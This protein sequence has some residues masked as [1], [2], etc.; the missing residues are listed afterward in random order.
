MTSKL[1]NEGEFVR[2]WNE[3]KSYEW[4]V[5]KYKSKYDIDIT[6]GAIGNW[7]ARLGL[8]RRQE[9]DM[10]LIP[11]A[12]RPEHRHRHAL[13]MLRALGR[14]RAGGEMTERMGQLLD[15]WLL[16]LQESDAVVY[17]DPDTEEGFFY[18]PREPGDADIIRRPRRSTRLRGKRE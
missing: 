3:G 13:G 7:R 17:Y 15:N 1:Q 8:D 16:S 4:I 9:R 10:D 14:R 11:W 6:I 5:N 2:W 18:V 12:V